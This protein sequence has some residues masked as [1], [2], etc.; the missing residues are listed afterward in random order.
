M[1]SLAGHDVGKKRGLRLAG[2]DRERSAPTNCQGPVARVV[3][4]EHSD[5]GGRFPALPLPRHRA[6]AKRVVAPSGPSGRGAPSRNDSA[7]L[8]LARFLICVPLRTQ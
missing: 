7:H 5:D 3:P 2:I 1:P 8:A 4:P 6:A